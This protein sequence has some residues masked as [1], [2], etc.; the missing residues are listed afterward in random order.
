MVVNVVLRYRLKKI[1]AY[2]SRHNFHCL[3]V[4]LINSHKLPNAEYEARVGLTAVLEQS[5]DETTPRFVQ[6]ENNNPL[7]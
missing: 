7:Y 4:T 5:I 2:F 3:F 6:R 1:S